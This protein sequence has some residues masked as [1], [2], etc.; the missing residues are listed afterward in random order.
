MVEFNARFTLGTV[1]IGLLRRTLGLLRREL[2]L[3]PG[4]RRYFY[5]G[6]DS[7]PEGW[8]SALAQAGSEARLLILSEEGATTR[9][10]LL[11]APRFGDLEHVVARAR[12]SGS[13]PS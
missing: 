4:N 7:P 5:F 8:E 3:E 2:G 9:P 13:R 10:A 6:L 11:L 12:R 1:V